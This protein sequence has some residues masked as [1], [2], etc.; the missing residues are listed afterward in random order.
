M[1]TAYKVKIRSVAEREAKIRAAVAASKETRDFYEF[2]SRLEKLSLVRLAENLLLYRMENFRTY[3]AQREYVLRDKKPSDY[4]LTGQENESIQQIQHEI[5]T[6]LARQ[7]RSDTVV[8]VIEV[9]RVEKQREPLLVTYRGVVVNGNRRLAGMRELWC[10]DKIAFSDFEYVNC[11]VLPE[12]ASVSEIVDIEA[13]LQ[14]KPETRLDY[15][16]IGDCQLIQ[17][18]LDLGKT[19]EE[20]AQRLNRKTSEIKNSLAALTE[21]NLYLKDWAKAEG[22]YSRV[23]EAEQFFNDLPGLLQGK[24]PTMTDASR[25]IAWNLFENRNSLR[26]R[27]YAFNPAVGKYAAVVLDRTAKALH[28]PLQSEETAEEGEFAVDVDTG[29]SEISY[30]PL[31]GALRDPEKKEEA[32]DALID[33]CRGVVETEKGKRTGSAAVRALTAAVNRLN[34]VDLGAAEPKTHSTIENL[35]TQITERVTGL[36]SVLKKLHPGSTDESAGPSDS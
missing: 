14:A 20:V 9:L 22:E 6:K 33:V 25:V 4:F 17:R 21:A 19:V 15:D 12:D 13:A 24:D 31:V 5:L 3:I 28:I 11:L 10:E 32:L 8:P 16:W 29:Q 7:G 26:E 30:Q 27:L 2:R 34:E 1:T 35:L 36:R 23:E 18:L